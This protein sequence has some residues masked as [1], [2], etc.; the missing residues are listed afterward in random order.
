MR[1]QGFR[2]YDPCCSLCAGPAEMIASWHFGW[3][4][5]DA[6]RHSNIFEQKCRL[7]LPVALSEVQLLYSCL[8]FRL[9]RLAGITVCVQSVQDQ[10]GVVGGSY[11]AEEVPGQSTRASH[12]VVFFHNFLLL[13]KQSVDD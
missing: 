3:Y 8:A 9:T 1:V 5:N 10:E 4:S 7:V 2:R 6:R 13:T 12:L 11:D